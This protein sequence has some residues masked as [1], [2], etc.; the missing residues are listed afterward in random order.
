MKS[1]KKFREELI[2]REQ[3]L[4]RVLLFEHEIYKNI[5][6]SNNS[7]RKDAENLNTNTIKHSHV[8]AKSNGRGSELYSVNYDG[9][10][11]DGSSGVQISPKHAD[12]FR[13]LGYSIAPDNILESLDLFQIDESHFSLFVLE[14]PQ[15]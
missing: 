11:H 1:F 8:Y 9:S 15:E 7:Y 4:Q 13:S 3:V 12:Y 5:P 10:G 2:H 14:N 6:G